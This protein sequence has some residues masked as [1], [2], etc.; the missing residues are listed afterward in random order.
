V[1]HISPNGQVPLPVDGMP[2]IPGDVVVLTTGEVV[3]LMAGAAVELT[4]G[5]LVTLVVGCVPCASKDEDDVAGRPVA[6]LSRAAGEVSG[7][8]RLA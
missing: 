5:C 4:I 1:L 3:V 7:A 8:D 2:L 6:V